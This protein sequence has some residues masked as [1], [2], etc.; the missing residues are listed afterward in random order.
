MTSVS[1]ENTLV[2]PGQSI[3]DAGGNTWGIN[4][5][6][7][8][9]IN[10]NA[11]ATTAHVT[12][13]AYVNGLVWQE[14]ASGLWWSKSSPT[15]PWSPQYGTE[16][17]PISLP[18]SV[19]GLPGAN[20]IY[21][22]AAMTDING[23]KWSIV[24][25]KVAVNGVVDPTTAN[26]KELAY[27]N[28]R[29]WQENAGNNWWSKT[30]PTDGW[31]ASNANPVS[32]SFNVANNY[33]DN[34]TINVGQITTAESAPAPGAVGT[35]IA[36]GVQATATTVSVSFSNSGTLV[37]NGNSSL[38]QGAT[39]TVL[40]AYRAP[41]PFFGQLENNGAM[42]VTGTPTT[43]AMVNIGTLSGTGHIAAVNATLNI[44]AATGD[45][46]QLTTS[47]LDIGGQGAFAANA[48]ASG[49]M[50][51]AAPITMDDASTITLFNTTATSEVLM[52]HAGRI[53][54]V[55]LY[56]GTTEV[57]ALNVSLSDPAATNLYASV[58]SVTSGTTTT[59]TVT[60]GTTHTAQD[61]PISIHTV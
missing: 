3:T 16:T 12:H 51:F 32:G 57:A 34:A 46:I 52:E 45:Q 24:G 18:A 50:S 39:L 27:A 10:G 55:D 20:A 6:G 54:A 22:G 2:T 14:N 36:A 30:M 38:S 1:P 47:Q 60:L 41:A 49:G 61:L 15:A 59:P 13:L 4:G 56:N 9:T 58:S 19:L 43:K 23:N 26:V 53:T 21:S 28:G 48:G 33:G 40:G 8:V 29:V 31:S 7:Q 11:D 35:I 37:L 17:V 44:Q 25:G 42:S 5:A